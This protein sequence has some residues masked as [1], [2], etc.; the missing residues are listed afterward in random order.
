MIHLHTD[1]KDHM[2]SGFTEHKSWCREY[3]SKVSLSS[4]LCLQQVVQN[5]NTFVPND[6]LVAYLPQLTI[7]YDS[8][9]KA[10]T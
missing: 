10:F 9:S 7:A 5:F 6:I 8:Y 4:T 2:S 1:F 3:L